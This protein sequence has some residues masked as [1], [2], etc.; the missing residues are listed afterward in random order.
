MEQITFF[1]FLI[2]ITYVFFNVLKYWKKNGASQSLKLILVY[3][4]AA[5]ILLLIHDLTWITLI[6]F[7]RSLFDRDSDIWGIVLLFIF[8]Y[9]ILFIIL[10]SRSPSLARPIVLI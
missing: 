6:T 4:V 1:I 7:L 9:Q 3:L 8:F 10:W 5:P 2:V